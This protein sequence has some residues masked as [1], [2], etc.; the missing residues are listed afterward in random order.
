MTTLSAL[1]ALLP[2]NLFSS[3]FNLND[4]NRLNG[5]NI[6]LKQAADYRKAGKHFKARTIY[7][8]I[9]D[10]FPQEIRAYDGIR[11][12]ILAKGKHE[13]EVIK[14]YKNA[15]LLNPGDVRIKE[16]L[17]KEYF[18]AA[19]GNKRISTTLNLGKRTLLDVK[20]KY[21]N[22]LLNHPNKKN[23][24]KQL[25]RIN[26]MIDS[27]IE[28]N[29]NAR[30]NNK[31]RTFKNQQR[32]SHKKRFD[33]LTTNKV[34]EKLAKLLS[35]PVSVDRKRH[36]RELNNIYIQ[37]L[38]KEK[39]YVLALDK[40]VAF[41]QL[42]KTDTFALKM[43]RDLA[44]HTKNHDLLIN[45]E[46]ENHSLKNNF[47]SACALFD[48]LMRK[49]EH[50]NITLTTEAENLLSFSFNQIN[51]P[52]HT[53]EVMTRKVKL[54]II[55]ND[56]ENAKVT[57]VDILSNKSGI[58]NAHIIDRLNILVAKY[59]KKINDVEKINKVLG[60]AM[61]PNLFKD[62]TDDILSSVVKL[63]INR[64]NTKS[65]HIENLQKFFNK[66]N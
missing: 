10:E 30:K 56:L 33:S 61:N 48:S 40:A 41:Y 65:I 45:I 24:A 54:L 43:V 37:R 15:L 2:N 57:L 42:D 59:F 55:R 5:L 58:S 31:L 3:T 32:K 13:L 9:I 29:L 21:E 51:E 44:K 60:I 7:N 11:K 25:E 64:S 62:E 34:N 8:Q 4:K 53:F 26:R 28:T 35:K 47:W 1:T 49:H 6:L 19:I 38:R 52:S 66:L 14:V 36:I 23:I 50:Q 39:N 20:E 63:N 18:K 12:I 46:R 22:F 17:F 16:R 27:N